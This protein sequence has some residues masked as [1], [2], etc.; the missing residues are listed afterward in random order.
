MVLNSNGNSDS[1]SDSKGWFTRT[2]QAQAQEN[3]R[4]NRDNAS[5]NAS[6]RKGNLSFFLHLHLCLRRPGSHVLFL[7]LVLMLASLCRTCEPALTVIVTVHVSNS[8]SNSNSISNTVIVTIYFTLDRTWKKKNRRLWVR[9]STSIYKQKSNVLTAGLL[10]KQQQQQ[11]Q[12]HNCLLYRCNYRTC[13][14]T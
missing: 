5:I 9:F 10:G 12:Q 13:A 8:N 14:C 2:T 3:I 1:D 4:V 11:Q 7:A 6:A